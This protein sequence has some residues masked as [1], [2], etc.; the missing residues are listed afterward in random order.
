MEDGHNAKSCKK[1]LSCIT[2]KERHP[3]PLHGYIPKNKKVTGDGNQSQTD[4][5]EVKTSFIADVECAGA[6]AKSESKVISMC[7]VP[8]SI[9]YKNNAKQIATYAML[10][11]CSQGSFVHEAVLKQLGV[12]GDKT[13]LSL[14]TL[15]GERSENTSAI[16]GHW[17]LLPKFYGRK[18]LPVDNEEIATPER[19]T[20]GEYLKPIT[21][22]IVQNDDV[23]IG[24]LIGANCMKTLE[25]MQVIASEN[26][27]PYVY[28]T[29]LGWCIVGPIMNGDIRI[30]SKDMLRGLICHL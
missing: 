23:Y 9:K 28:I 18:D 7:I 15:H 25:P 12:K 17:L 6:L 24:L 4:Q 30:Q 13:T 3:A 1:R 22:E 26:G 14:K 29:R 20:E 11:N 5:E 10:D 2:C 16:A 27:G 21:K 19:I 8:V